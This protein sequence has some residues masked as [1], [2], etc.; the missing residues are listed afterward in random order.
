M[1]NYV[2]Y[3]NML[4]II[5]NNVYIL[6]NK[7]LNTLHSYVYMIHTCVYIHMNLS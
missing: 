5:L 2:Y 4:F 1:E 7:L 3:F 6:N